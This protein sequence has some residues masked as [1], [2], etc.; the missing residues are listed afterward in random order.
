MSAIEQLLILGSVAAVVL[1]KSIC[2]QVE[3][4]QPIGHLLGEG[5]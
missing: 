1:V 5:K 2:D 3:T 4:L